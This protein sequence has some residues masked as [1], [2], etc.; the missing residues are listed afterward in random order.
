MSSISASAGPLDVQSIVS[1]LIQ[2]DSQPLAQSRQRA[3]TYQSEL[4]VIGQ[5]SS[6]L[7]ALQSAASTLQSGS[8]L[9][10]FS[11]TS[12]DS[13]VASVSTSSG[14]AAGTY[15]LNVSQLAKSR[16]LVFDQNPN[17]SAIT[18]QNAAISGAP[19]SLSF[20][21]GGASSTVQL[22]SNASLSSIANSINGAG[23][24]VNA[25]IV[26][27]NNTY[28]LVLSSAQAGPGNAFSI[29]AGGTDSNNTSGNT[30]AGLQQSATAASESANAQSALMTVNGVNVSSDSNSVT[31][32]VNGA[33]INLEKTGQV[34][35][36][37]AQ[38]TTNIT[39]TL[40]TFINAYNQV[41]T[42]TA[43]ATQSHT[44]VGST[45]TNTD[46]SGDLTSLQEHMASI[47]GT[48]VKG[49][50][51]TSSYAYLA[52]VGITQKADGTLTLDSSA[53]NAAL[54]ANPSAVANLFGN[55]QN[56]GVANVFNTTINSLLGPNG[57]ITSNQTNLN[58]KVTAEQQ[59]QERLQNQLNNEQTS[60]LTEYS[61]L[62][63]E[64]AQMQQASSSMANLIA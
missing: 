30:L 12:S 26:Q 35:I 64:L 2:A 40:Q 60:L 33:T 38:S 31:S 18:D 61:N 32:V 5:V 15:V 54:T 23:I 19:S 25:S 58:S 49:V 47:L 7:S 28:S 10:Q 13:T 53:F 8:F 39:N 43:S 34:T 21:V 57:L 41:I 42:T 20:S 63:S 11:A 55:S 59:L 6:A 36:N 29:T 16:Q 22:G 62:N 4:S 14:G 52:Q 27:Y 24:G 51:A 44:T 17:G 9:Q 46:I 37:M 48:P 50:D 3:S 56:T 1:Q 45:P